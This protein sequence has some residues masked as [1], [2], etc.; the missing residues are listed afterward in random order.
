MKNLPILLL[1]GVLSAGANSAAAHTYGQ[2]KFEVI[3]DCAKHATGNLSQ[4]F[5]KALAEATCNGHSHGGSGGINPAGSSYSNGDTMQKLALPK[6]KRK[7]KL[8]SQN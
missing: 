6:P 3:M 8:Q 1:V 2:C 5:C 4:Q 7:Q